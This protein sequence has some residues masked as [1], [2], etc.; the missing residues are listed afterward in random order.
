MADTS[1]W[2]DLE[3]PNGWPTLLL[4]TYDRVKKN[5]KSLEERWDA[6]KVLSEVQPAARRV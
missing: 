1:V 4:Q 2:H 5:L 3:V 6:K